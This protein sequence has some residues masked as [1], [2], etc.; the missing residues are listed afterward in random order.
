MCAQYFRVYK[1][2]SS[3]LHSDKL[4]VNFSTLFYI[5]EKQAQRED[6]VCRGSQN[7]LSD[8]TES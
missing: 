5:L 3:N 1:T 7:Q 2:L 6:V 8:V 4:G